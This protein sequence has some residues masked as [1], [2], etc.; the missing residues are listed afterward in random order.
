MKI[1]ALYFPQFH[2]I[3]ENDAWWGTGFTD[4]DNVR[5]ARKQFD[6]HYQPREPLNDN[7]YDQSSLATI[8][9]QVEL[10]RKYG[11]YGFCHYHY[12]FDGVHLLQTP[13]ELLL[14][15]PDIDMPFCLSWA[16]ETWTRRWYGM[17]E[18]ILIEQT[19]P[20]ATA[21][22]RRHFDYLIRAWKDPRAIKI[23]GKPVFAI[24]RPQQIVEIDAMLAAWRAWAL[25]A[26]LPG[27]YIMFQKQSNLADDN[28]LAS[29]D[30]Q[31]QFQPCEAMYSK[32]PAESA[33]VPRGLAR[34]A[35]HLLPLSIQRSLRKLRW[36]LGEKKLTI[37]DYEEIWER[38][39]RIPAKTNLTTFPGAF[40]DWDNTAR[41]RN[42][43]TLFTGA[44]PE[45]FQHWL[46]QLAATMAGRDLPED[47]VFL[48]AWNEWSEGTYLEPDKVHGYRYLEALGAVLASSV[49]NPVSTRAGLQAAPA[50]EAPEQSLDRPMSRR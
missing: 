13:T 35:F 6:G 38:V 19:H 9:W 23:D 7:Y 27:L 17:D 4:W 14:Q 11:I 37:F 47:F 16:N 39:T 26:G 32:P 12:W 45:R 10:A 29:F 30:G 8:R 50:R 46:R 5:T 15:N 22:W 48:N 25:E 49:R 28:C 3:K 18:D 44:S 1:I 41:Y 2:P 43:A 21:S 24:Y 42:L 20:P 31:F 33:S 34:S 36:S 40:L